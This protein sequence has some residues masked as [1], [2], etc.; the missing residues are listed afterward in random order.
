VPVLHPE[1]GNVSALD[2]YQRPNPDMQREALKGV[3]TLTRPDEAV[4]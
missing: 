4:E 2:H 1:H 3:V